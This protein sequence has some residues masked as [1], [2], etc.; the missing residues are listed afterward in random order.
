MSYTQMDYPVLN[1]AYF[2]SSFIACLRDN[3]KYYLIPH[4]S[5]TLSDTYW[6]AK[7]LEKGILVKK[8]L[9]ILPSSLTKPSSTYNLPLPPKPP[10]TPNH[11]TTQGSNTTQHHH[12]PV[13]QSHTYQ[14]KRVCKM[15]GVP[16]ALDTRA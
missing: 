16:R 2:V 15:L 7:E 6:K 5:Q 3:I 8:S 4:H 10:I 11:I 13:H 9:L 12:L 1:E 14:S